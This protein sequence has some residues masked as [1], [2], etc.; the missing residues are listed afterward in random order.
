MLLLLLLLGLCRR[1]PRAPHRCHVPPAARLTPLHTW[2][3]DAATDLSA[4]VKRK[5]LGIPMQRPFESCDAMF[6]APESSKRRGRREKP[7][8]DG[9]EFP[10]R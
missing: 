6:A 3:T 5:R 1:A 8:H 2:R 4:L 10:L 7:N 9:S